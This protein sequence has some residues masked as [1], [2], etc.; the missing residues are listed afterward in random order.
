MLRLGS[1]R[2]HAA[3]TF[4]VENSSF[5]PNERTAAAAAESSDRDVGEDVLSLISIFSF[6]L[7]SYTK[8]NRSAIVCMTGIAAFS[9]LI[10]MNW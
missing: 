3:F 6:F 10:P 9:V 7:F 4:S 1:V 8:V 2:V 5:A